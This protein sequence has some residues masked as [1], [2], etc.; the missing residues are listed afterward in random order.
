MPRTGHSAV[1]AA[2]LGVALLAPPFSPAAIASPYGRRSSA[3][4][5][6]ATARLQITYPQEGTLFPP[7]IVA[8]PWSGRTRPRASTAGTW[9]C[10]TTPAARCCARRSTRRAGVRRGP[11]GARSKRRSAE[12]DAEVIVAGV[13]QAAWGRAVRG[14]RPHPDLQG[15]GRRCALLS[16]GAAAVPHRRP[17]PLPH[18]WR[19]GTIDQ[20]PGRRSCCRTCR[21][22][23]TALFRGQWQR[24]RAR[25]RLR[26]DKG[27][28][29]SCRC[30]RTW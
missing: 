21:C 6:A 11:L 20:R 3:R 7:E 10:A 24:A 8:R 12:R 5:D 29:A 18:R 15:S 14:A 26:N 23:A 30:P 17:G 4:A 13:N 25:R 22:A 1:I 27:A 28:T 9:W 16:R 19:F 2:I